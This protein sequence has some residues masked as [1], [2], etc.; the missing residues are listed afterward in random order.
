[1]LDMII[2]TR[3]VALSQ[4]FHLL[5]MDEDEYL[6]HDEMS[7]FQTFARCLTKPQNQI[8]PRMPNRRWMV[9]TDHRTMQRDEYAQLSVGSHLESFTLRERTHHVFFG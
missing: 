4:M 1:M 3:A 6:D 7:R 2:S 8:Q 9:A 5:D